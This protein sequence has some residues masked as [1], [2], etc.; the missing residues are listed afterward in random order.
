MV[1]QWLHIHIFGVR[2]LFCVINIKSH[3]YT[4]LSLDGSLKAEI[5][6]VRNTS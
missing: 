1:V 2:M 6:P 3:A 4:L 5:H